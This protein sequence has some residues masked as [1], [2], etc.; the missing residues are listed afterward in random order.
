MKHRQSYPPQQPPKRCRRRC[1]PGQWRF[2]TRTLNPAPNRL[3]AIGAPIAPVPRTATFIAGSP[4]R[5]EVVIFTCFRIAPSRTG[6][7]TADTNQ[8]PPAPGTSNTRQPESA[9][10]DSN[11]PVSGNAQ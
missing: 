4:L 7:A 2:Q 1:A 8:W 11:I 9:R 6:V 3:R 10:V 5:P